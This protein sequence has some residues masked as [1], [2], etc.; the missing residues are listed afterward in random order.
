MKKSFKNRKNLLAL[1]LSALMLTSAATLASC[2]DSS[3]TDSSSSSSSSTANTVVKDTGL[4]KNSKF[5]NDLLKDT[6]PM[7][8]SVSNWTRT[9]IGNA[10]SSKAASGAIDTSEEAWKN[11]TGSY[12]TNPDEVKS[13]TESQAEAAWDNL[14]VRD[15]LAYYEAWEDAHS[16]GDIDEDL[17]FYES[18]N[19]DFG[20]IPTIANPGTPLK[21]SDEGYGED[22]KILMIH[23]ENPEASSTATY[24]TLGTAQKYTSGTTVTVPAG[25]AAKL[26]LWVKTADLKSSSSTGSSQDAVGKG[27]FISL[28]HSVGSESLPEYK[29][30]NIATDEW[31]QYS[32]YLQG[33]S[34]TD[35][36]F[37][38]VLGLGQDVGGRLGY[39][40]GYAFFDQIECELID[41]EDYKTATTGLN[42]KYVAGFETEKDNKIIDAYTDSQTTFAL[43]FYNNDGIENL[44]FEDVNAGATVTEKDG[45]KYSTIE[46]SGITLPVGLDGS[47]ATDYDRYQI[48]NNAS[49][50]ENDLTNNPY[51]TNV[52]NNYLKDN[53]FSKDQKVMLLLSANGAAYKVPSQSVAF[54]DYNSPDV[55]GE[56]AEYLMI[57]VFVKTSDMH[58]KT[59]AGITLVDGNTKTS[60]DAI[61]TSDIAPVTLGENEDVYAGWQQYFFFV[62][63]GEDTAANIEFTL[64]FTFGPTEILATSKKT[65]FLEGF[66]AF[67]VP[68]IR[69]MS[70]KEYECVS[71]GTYAKT[72]TINGEK[73]DEAAG[74]G[75]FDSAAATPSNALDKGLA[76]LKNYKGVY[77]DSD[78]VTGKNNNKTTYNVNKNA[79]LLNKDKFVEDDGVFSKLNGGT[80]AWFNGLF[81]GQANAKDAWANVIGNDATQPLVI[82]NAEAKAYGFIGAS[83]Q[84]AANTY[85]AVSVR[86]KGSVGATANVYLIDTDDTT[87]QSTLSIGRQRTYWYTDDGD[88]AISDPTEHG[89]NERTDIAFFRKANGLYVV[90]KNWADKGDI[91]LDAYYANLS[92]YEQDENGNLV[93][94][95]NGISYD[96][97]DKWNNDGVIDIVYHK[98]DNGYYTTTNGVKT[99]V[100]DL[101][102]VS[103]LPARYT[104]ETAKGL[105]QTV[106]TNGEWATVTFYIHTGNQAKNYRLEV[107]SGARNGETVNAAGSYV[108]FDTNTAADATTY[109]PKLVE[110]YKDDDTATK[111]EGVFSFFDSNTFRRYDETLDENKIGNEYEKSFVPSANASGIAYLVKQ[112]D[113]TYY[114]IADYALSEVEV[115][116][117]TET[118][119]ETEEEEETADDGTNIWLLASSVAI[120]A[121][122]VLAV[123]SLIVQKLLKKHRKKSGSKAR[124]Q[125]AVKAKKSKKK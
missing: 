37:T 117:T 58:G 24:K 89:F 73:N 123:V 85:T 99:Y 48:Y 63:K 4:I 51:L 16:D 19:I 59:G 40:N 29:V 98:D 80:T 116:K 23:N 113:N 47:L 81:D 115:T 34:Y 95:K 56:K 62:E 2:K 14:T 68:T 66:A 18:F 76:N 12:Y 61:D 124:E 72:V 110:Q 69:A 84:I 10:V 36:T 1:C 22:N 119:T 39:V 106:E 122:L 54:A 67:T 30:S 88:I 78:Y 82:Y 32:F 35:S 53:A 21:E 55:S 64:E 44:D 107:W 8:T 97:S 118:D 83:T 41:Q 33:S 50:F 104:A 71:A 9:I 45:K 70:Q 13:L 74:N 65:D 26:S 111:F 42:D 125:V 27:A 87:Y 49:E 60:F 121:I 77:S 94:G 79:G 112:D 6:T 109:M 7:I 102:S 120:A 52:Y 92:N 38:L 28:T 17:S 20:D 93:I 3:S 31:K 114:T 15:K 75:G 105:Q 100:T 108:L 96:Y 5:E 90:N 57:S 86:V 25:A 103:A 91:P 46:R 11:L 101:A 43:D